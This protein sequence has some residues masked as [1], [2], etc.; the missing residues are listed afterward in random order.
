MDR[1]VQCLCDED[2]KALV[3]EGTES[4]SVLAAVW[5]N[6]LTEYYEL[7]GDDIAQVEQWQL[8]RDV[9]RLN[10]HLFLIEKCITVL[11]DRWSDSLAD[12]IRKLG[13]VFSPVSI[14][15]GEYDEELS[16]VINRSKTKYIHLQQLTKALELQISGLSDK[17][18]K[19]E[20]FD[21]LLVQIEEMQRVAYTLES[22]TVQKFI[23]LEKKYWHHIE[24]IKVKAANHGK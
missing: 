14:V 24:L 19:R 20:Y 1:F 17:K 6:I 11:R 10:N 9:T 16:R 23:T 4:E 8:T 15:P 5:M 7:R 18:P 13:Y 2:F 12:S 3:I 21:T 22:I